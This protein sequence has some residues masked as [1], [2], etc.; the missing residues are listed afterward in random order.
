[1][2]GVTA[3]RLSHDGPSC[4]KPLS[5]DSHASQPCAP[6]SSSDSPSPCS[7]FSSSCSSPSS[8]SSAAVAAASFSCPAAGGLRFGSSRRFG[9]AA[10]ACASVGVSVDARAARDFYVCFRAG[11]LQAIAAHSLRQDLAGFHPSLVELPK[12]EN[13]EESLADV[14][15]E[16]ACAKLLLA[17]DR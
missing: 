1:M 15:G 2:T 9:D 3:N 16:A 5:S 14:G 13:R 8:S 6:R 17:V 4:D 11:G 10:S 12:D 7:S